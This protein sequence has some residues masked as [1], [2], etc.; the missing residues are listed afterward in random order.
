MKRSNSQSLSTGP[1]Q[2]RPF[3]DVDHKEFDLTGANQ[4]GNP[5]PSEAIVV[6]DVINGQVKVTLSGG[7]LQE[8]V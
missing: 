1:G 6:G 4:K 8:P 3:I 5:L 7:F 2:I